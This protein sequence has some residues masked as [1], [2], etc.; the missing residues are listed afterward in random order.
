MKG[1]PATGNKD[2]GMASVNGRIRSALPPANSATGS[3]ALI[4]SPVNPIPE[5][6][7]SNGIE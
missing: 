3:E 5:E 2:F 4:G 1:R 7:E 6:L